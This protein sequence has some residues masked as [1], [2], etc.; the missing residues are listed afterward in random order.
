M[1]S[2]VQ[3][4]HPGSEHTPRP[5]RLGTVMPWNTGDHRRKFLRAHGSCL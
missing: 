3:F 1:P 5:A 4:P 2:F